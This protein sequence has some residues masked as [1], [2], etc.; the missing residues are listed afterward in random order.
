MLLQRFS[1]NDLLTS[2]KDMQRLQ[3]QLNRLLS[4]STA[5]AQIEFPPVNV[6]TS[7]SG[8]IVQ[9]DIPGIAPE[10]VE[11]SLVNNTLTIRGSR[12]PEEPKEGLSCHRQERGYGQFTRTLRLPFGIQS[13]AVEARFANGVLEIKL[14]R[15]EAEKPRKI[16]VQCE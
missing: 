12:N 4:V 7:A 6:W 5:G 10:D 13:D 15:A 11:I 8:A 9:A 14:P 1:D 16:N 2:L 3:T